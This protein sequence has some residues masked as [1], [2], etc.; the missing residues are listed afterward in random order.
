MSQPLMI[1]QKLREGLC[2][3][4]CPS[5]PR[6][7]CTLV[8]TSCPQGRGAQGAQNHPDYPQRSWGT[9]GKDPG[10]LSCPLSSWEKPL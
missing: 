3:A 2:V 6:T 4:Q 7:S 10:M 5:C 1:T 8:V 9:A